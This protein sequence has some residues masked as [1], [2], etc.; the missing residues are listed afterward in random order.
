MHVVQPRPGVRTDG[1]D[2]GNTV[3]MTVRT[4]QEEAHRDPLN[5]DLAG[6]AK[7]ARN[8]KRNAVRAAKQSYT[9]L[10]L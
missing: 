8:T 7:T 10:K 1:L 2:Y 3:P 5:Q 6:K 4:L 9:M